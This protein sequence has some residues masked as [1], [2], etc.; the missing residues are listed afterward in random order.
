MGLGPGSGRNGG[1]F[2]LFHVRQAFEHIAQVFGR[3]DPVPSA[4]AQ[5]R[6]DDC[7]T[8][9]RIRVPDEEE[10]LLADGRGPDGVIDE[11]M[12]PPDL[13]RVAA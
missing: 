8:P 4:A 5:D 13:C 2:A 11:I 10:V 9:T 3:V 1:D 12:P 6:V 7:A